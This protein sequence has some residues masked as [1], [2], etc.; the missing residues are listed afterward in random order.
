[1]FASGAISVSASQAKAAGH[2]RGG[3]G[4]ALVV[5]GERVLR[6]RRAVD[7]GRD[8]LEAAAVEPQVE[9]AV[10]GARRVAAE[11]DAGADPG[12]GRVRARR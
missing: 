2:V 10:A 6:H 12:R 9:R 4:Q 11:G 7:R 5:E 3:D 8:E 1:M